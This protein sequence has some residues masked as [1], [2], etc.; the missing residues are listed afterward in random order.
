MSA[1]EAAVLATA[2]I[3]RK[4]QEA[5][6]M[7]KPIIIYR[8]T[9]V[10][11]LGANTL[12]IRP[13]SGHKVRVICANNDTTSTKVTIYIVNVNEESTGLS[14][15]HHASMIGAGKDITWQCPNGIYFDGQ[16]K[17]YVLFHKCAA[18]DNLTV[19][20]GVE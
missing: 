18:N 12:A 7:G 3:S 10:A 4:K 19:T 8:Q 15:V 11:I 13:P 17:I 2:L 14:L 20:I 5:E 16:Q 9:K 6:E 1:I